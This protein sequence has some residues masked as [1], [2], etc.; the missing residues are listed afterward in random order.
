MKSHAYELGITTSVNDKF[1]NERDVHVHMP[2]G[3][4][5]KEG[6]SVR[7]A[8]LSA[9]VSLFTRTGISPDIGAFHFSF[10]RR[11]CVYCAETD[12]T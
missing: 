1:L 3:S 11:T 5:D 9:F 12:L 4:I 6:P 7:I 8:I 2:E 10:F